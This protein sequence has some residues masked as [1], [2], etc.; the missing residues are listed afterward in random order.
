MRTQD[1]DSLSVASG[2]LH[3]GD[4]L[5]ILASFTDR[6]SSLSFSLKCRNN[7]S[8]VL[9]SGNGVV[10][11]FETELPHC[12]LP[13]LTR[14]SLRLTDSRRSRTRAVEPLQSPDRYLLGT[15]PKADY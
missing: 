5:I 3:A 10:G 15:E 13:L 12:L 2:P 14:N 8:H 9:S 6:I 4:N 1:Y 11:Y 7:F